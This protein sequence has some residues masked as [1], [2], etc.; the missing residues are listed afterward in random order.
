MEFGTYYQPG[1]E[2]TAYLIFVPAWNNSHHDSKVYKVKG[3]LSSRVS[4]YPNSTSTFQI[5]R[6]IISGDIAENPGPSTNKLICPECSRS[7]AKNHRSL[8]CSVC[9]LT[10]NI[11]CGNATP[12]N[13]KLIQRI[14]PMTWKC[15][16][17]L[18]DI[19]FDLNELPFASLSE[20]SFISMVRT[21]PL[22]NESS[23]CNF[24][25]D[26]L[27]E[28]AQK[29]NASPNDSSD[30]SDLSPID[31][32]TSNINSYYKR[33]LKIGHLNVNSIYGKAD[34]VIDLLNTCRFDIFFVAES[35]IDGSVNS[36]LFAHSEY[37]IIRRDRMKGGGRM[38]VYIRRSI[39]AL[40]RARLEPDGV[41]SICLD[42]KGCGN[43]WF[44]ICACYRSPGKCKISD[45]LSSC[46]LAAEKM[47]TKRKEVM[48]LGDLILTC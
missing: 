11:K 23:Q 32:F 34:E 41:E 28:I 44:L 26:H 19:S 31:W 12:K 24:D 15:P 38:L 9:D 40:R 30:E 17:C 20:E 5:S 3:Y 6:L 10:Y 27:G 14:V 1:Q 33:N 4:R 35:K 16:I 43:S 39:T 45:F 22:Y 13:F 47:Y 25:N 37:R 46:V 8:T 42:V 36:S 2:S 7:I 18:D 21:D 48:F 29:I